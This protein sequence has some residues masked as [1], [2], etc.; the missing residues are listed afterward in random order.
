MIA[1]DLRLRESEITL[2]NLFSQAGYRTGYIGKWHL[3]GGPR[4]PGFV[5]PGPRRHGFQYWAANECWHNYFYGWYFRDENVPIIMTEYEPKGWTDIAIEF[6]YEN[7]DQKQPFFLMLSPGAP[8][9]PYIVPEEF[10]KMYEP[11]ALSIRPNWVEGTQGGGRKEIAAYYAAITAI[12]EQVGR[13]MKVLRELG[14]EK[15]TIVVF[16]SDHGNMLGSQGT[17]L[18]RKPWEESICVPGI[19]RYPSKV[20]GGRETDTLLS[21]VDL[22]PTLLSLCQIAV[23]GDIQGIDLS[24]VIL[25]K[26]ESGPESAYFQIF[27]PNQ[28]DGTPRAWRG[29]RTGRYMYA[30]WESEPWLLYNLEKDPYEL[31]NLATE[32]SASSIRREMDERVADWMKRVGDSWSLDWVVPVE[33][34]GRLVNY[35][36][37][38]TV[39]EY[40]KWAKA[41]PELNPGS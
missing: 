32:P 34:G 30:R 2:G 28:G 35:R 38:Y 13:L 9:D 39:D 14:M 24:D 11:Q 18:K 15:N 7:R 3:D 41:H 40:V 4:I 29:V 1:N 36:T 23:P 6:L 37:F 16:T 22:C 17:I 33:D 8:H 31:K 21:H 12:D 10:L 27:G 5:P 25:G 19:I 26:Q 20:S